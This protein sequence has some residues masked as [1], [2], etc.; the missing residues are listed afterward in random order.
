MTPQPFKRASPLMKRPNGLSIGAVKN[1]AAIAP[2][3]D[4]SH[5]VQHTQ[6]LGYRW[7]LKS[8]RHDD[9]A[10]RTLSLCQKTK[11]GAAAR[12]RHGVEGV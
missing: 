9:I 4:E 3:A 8:E 7:L 2:G 10:N 11:N 1:L 12:F 6:V 5:F